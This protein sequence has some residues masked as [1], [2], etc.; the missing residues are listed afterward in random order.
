MLE[1][2][3]GIAV[4]IGVCYDDRQSLLVS[5]SC[6]YALDDLKVSPLAYSI[7]N[8]TQL[9]ASNEFFLQTSTIQIAVFEIGGK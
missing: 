7:H 2:A 5:S 1:S 3:V 4:L 8:N 9:L 6:M